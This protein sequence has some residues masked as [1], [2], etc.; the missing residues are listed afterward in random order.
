[1]MQMPSLEAP[2]DAAVGSFKSLVLQVGTSVNHGVLTAHRGCLWFVKGAT[3]VLSHAANAASCFF[4]SVLCSVRAFAFTDCLLSDFGFWR[5]DQTRWWE[6]SWPQWRS[7]FLSA[8][9]FN[10]DM[11]GKSA[12]YSSTARTFTIRALW[13]FLSVCFMHIVL[14][15]RPGNIIL[16]AC[17]WNGADKTGW[18]IWL[19]WRVSNVVNAKLSS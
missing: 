6:A 7:S 17:K 1:M 9:E 15:F 18:N 12:G 8:V 3:F 5:W 10:T 13:I 11:S 2:P 19:N 14:K 4:A 16:S